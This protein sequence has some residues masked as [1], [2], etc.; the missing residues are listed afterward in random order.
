MDL[1]LKGRVALVTAASR[2]IGRACALTL[3]AEGADVAICARDNV[4]LQKAADDIRAHSDARVHAESADVTSSSDINRLVTSTRQA[5]GAIDILVAIGGAPPRGG[6]AEASEEKMRLA[7]DMTVNSLY[8]L[9]SNVLP[10]MR[11]RKWGRIITVQARSVR[12]PIPDLMLSNATRPGAAGLIKYLSFEAAQ[13]NVLM[14]TILPGRFMTDRLLS[15]AERS[16]LS[17]QDFL[18]DQTHDLPI[19]RLGETQEMANVVAFLA[20]ERASYITGVA[21]PVDGGLIRSI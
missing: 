13:D 4:E 10:E 6:L 12:E 15:A 7:F 5:L 21:L 16:P 17:R 3:A 2:G 11:L 9:I 18:K 8:C 19:G 20:S 1:G 14:N